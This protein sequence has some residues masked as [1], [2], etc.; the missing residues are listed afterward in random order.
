[1][2]YNSDMLNHWS[3]NTKE[4]EK[5]PDAFAIWR[6]EQWANWG[7]GTMKVK[8]ADLIKYWD[9]LDIDQ[10]KKKALALALF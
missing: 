5:D 8:K 9:R 4:L 3:V 2:C 1:M 6:L 10:W 7:I